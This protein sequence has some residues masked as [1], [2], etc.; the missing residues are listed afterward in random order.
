MYE[1]APLAVLGAGSWGTAVAI[2][3]AG[4]GHQCLLWDHNPSRAVQIATSRRNTRY[5]DDI[6]LPPGV[7][8]TGDLDRVLSLANDFVIAIP[9]AAFP[10]FVENLKGHLRPESRIVWLTKGLVQDSA[11]TLDRAVARSL[12]EERPRAVLSG[13]SFAMEVARGQPTA[14]TVASSDPIFAEIVAGWLRSPVFRVYT[15]D[16]ILGVELGGALKNVL[17]I[18]VGISDGQGYGANARAALITRG[19]AELMRLFQAAGARPETL[20]GL[21]GLGDLVLTCTD[22]QSRNRRLGLALGRGAVLADALCD[23]GQVV[24]GVT[25][26]E[27]VMRVAE[28]YG[29]ELPICEQV[30]RVVHEG[31]SVQE[32]G[33]ALLAR[34]PR[35]EIGAAFAR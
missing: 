2:L 17:A 8:P 35:P 1:N 26:S 10:A 11:D 33:R 28:R 6:M 20:M 12:G 30:Y 3:L 4:N 7:M 34:E 9:S 24:E 22:N 27:A 18:A 23:I 31:L 15:S 25:T 19:L 21:S 32:A 13:P 16:D 29:V 5:L 14:V